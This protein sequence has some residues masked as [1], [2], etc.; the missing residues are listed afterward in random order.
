MLRI[1]FFFWDR[2]IVIENYYMFEMASKRVV[3]GAS[4][5]NLCKIQLQSDLNKFSTFAINRLPNIELL[6]QFFFSTKG[7][8]CDIHV[9]NMQTE[10]KSNAEKL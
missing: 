4:V 7:F 2:E 10:K 1:F 5:K 9:T 3:C 6:I 8:V